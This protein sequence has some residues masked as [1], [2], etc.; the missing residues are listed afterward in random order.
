MDYKFCLKLRFKYNL[1][2]CGVRIVT[3]TIAG[4]YLAYTDPAMN[5]RPSCEH[6]AHL[7]ASN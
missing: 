5:E 4:N 3:Y 2:I 6:L 1:H 7:I